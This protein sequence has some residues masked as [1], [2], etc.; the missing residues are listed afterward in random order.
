MNLSVLI[1]THACKR[2]VIGPFTNLNQTNASAPSTKLIET[3]ISNIEDH[4]SEISLNFIIGLDHKT[5]VGLSNQYLENLK[6]LES[7]NIRVTSV[8][9]QYS[10]R[11]MTTVTA[12]K[13]FLNL[14]SMCE[15]NTFLLWEHDWVFTKPIDNTKLDIEKLGI[16]MLRFNQSSNKTHHD[17]ETIFQDEIGVRTTLFSNNPFITSKKVWSDQYEKFALDIPDWWGKY[18]AFI[19]GP[20]NRY[21]TENN[22]DYKIHV[23]GELGDEP[24]IA[25]LN[26][27]VWR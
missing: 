7:Q 20:I 9:T 24:Y 15:T 19:E 8:N 6:K 13:N 14:I 10:D 22:L 18:G 26:G 1:P 5:D 16:E 4:L 23:Y 17:E 25:H 12:T 2:E 27:Q 21:M 11:V 3:I